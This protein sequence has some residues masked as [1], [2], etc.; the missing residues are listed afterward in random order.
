MNM[1]LEQAQSIINALYSK[2]VLNLEIDKKD[3]ENNIE[4]KKLKEYYRNRDEHW[5]RE[6]KEKQY[7]EAQ[8][9][10]TEQQMAEL[11]YLLGMER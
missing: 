10:L 11:M 4:R 7:E 8:Q 3:K 9:T 2:Y 6:D 5:E 1:T